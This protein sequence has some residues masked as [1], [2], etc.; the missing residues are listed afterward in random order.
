MINQDRGS[1]VL[2]F[3]RELIEQR[4]YWLQRLAEGW[5]SSGLRL[6]SPRPPVPSGRRG[7]VEVRIAGEAEARLAKLSGGQPFLLFAALMTGLGICLHRY[8]GGRRLV[9]GT[10]AL[11][12][13]GAE[14]PV[15]AVVILNVVEPGQ[16][17]RQLLLATRQTL[18]DAYARQDFPF[19]RLVE[20]KAAGAPAGGCPLFDVALVLEGL[21]GPLPEVGN[22]LTLR[23]RREPGVLACALSFDADVLTAETVLRFALHLETV[24]AGA[25]ADANAAV[26]RVPLL[27]EAEQAQ[28][29]REWN[30][31]DRGLPAFSSLKELFEDR[32][33]RTPEAV[34]ALYGEDSLTYGELNRRA[35]Q[36]AHFLHG[37]GVAPETLV[38]I[39]VERSFDM[40]TAVAGVLKA[41]GA[42]L[43]L[44][45][46]Y[47]QER[48]EL[49]VRD[50]GVPVLLTEEAQLG[51]LP[52]TA[53]RVVAMDRERA[54]IAACP[55][56]DP[57]VEV[58]PEN[59]A[60]VIYTS[61][62][63]GLP[64]GTQI[65]HAGVCNL[66]Q[67]IR[68][69]GVSAEDRVL[70]FAPL[71]FDAAVW[72]IVMA[73]DAGAA[74]CLGTREELHPGPDMVRLLQRRRVTVAS[75]PPSALAVLPE[76]QLKS[77]HMVVTA[78]EACPPEV[79][80]RWAKGRRLLNGY[81]PTEIT[82]GTGISRIAGD[83]DRPVIGYPFQN[84]R[85]FIL[86]SELRP[87]PVG[88]PGEVHVAGIGLAR[89][90]LGRPDLTAERFIPDPWSG[91][92]GGRLYK[93]GDVGRLMPD[94]TFDFL[95]RVDHQV[96][97][98]GLRVEL[99]EIESAL[100]LHPIAGEVV[101]DVREEVLVAWVV[102]RTGAGE[103][104]VPPARQLRE[105]LAGRLP[106]YMVPQ[107]FV[108]LAALPLSPSGKLDRR[109]L[110]APAVET[111]GREASPASLNPVE[112]VIAGLVRQV[113][114]SGS[115]GVRDDFFELGGNS[116]LAT[117]VVSRVAEAFQAEISLRGF[118]EE[119][120][121]AGLARQVEAAAGL[122]REVP[123]MVP[124]SR[125]GDL[126][127]SFSQQRLWF[128]DR[129]Q[130]GSALYNVPLAL[131]IEGDLDLDLLARS[132]GE[133]VRRHEVLRTVFA[134]KDGQPVQ[135]V[136]PFR[137]VDLPLVDLRGLPAEQRLEK[138][139]ETAKL[140]ARRPFDLAR[141]PLLRAAVLRLAPDEHAVLL[142]L[143][144]IASDGWSLGILVRE[145]TALFAGA[146]LEPLPIQYADFAAWQ[147][148]WLQGEVLEAQLDYWRRHLAGA[149]PVLDLPLDRP[150]PAV[151]SSHGASCGAA[152]TPELSDALA[153]VARAQ[154]VPLFMVLLSAYAVLLSRHGG[155]SDL[156][157]GTPIANRNRLETEKLIGFFVNTLALRVDLAAA[158][159]FAG[160]LRQV[161]QAAIGAYA[162]QDLPFEKLV[163][164]LRPAAD[165]SHT[166]L[167]QAMFVLQTP[168][169]EPR[170][171]GLALKP[172]E[173]DP[174]VA[175]FD[176]TLS[177][178]E[179]GGRLRAYLQYST[180]LFDAATVR[181]LL[182]HWETL[183]AGV[184]ADP[185]ARLSALPLLTAAE[186]QAVLVE[187]AGEAVP[188][189]EDACLHEIFAARAAE[190]P[191]TLAVVFEDRELTYAELD[192]RANR[193][194]HR[195]RRR[196]VGPEVRVALSLER[197]PEM[198]VALLAVMK[199]G[200]AYVPID[201]TYP[202]E[203]R[204]LML[205]DSGALLLLTQISLAGSL[206]A[207]A[208]GLA[209]L[210]GEEEEGGDDSAPLSGAAPENAAYVIYTSGSTGR[211]K[212]V[213]V[214]HRGLAN[215][216]TAQAL[217]FGL[218]PGAQVL[219]FSSMS[220]DASVFEIVMALAVGSTLVLARRETLIP[221][222][223]MIAL[224][225]ERRVSHV[226][227]PPS[228]LAALP[229]RDLPRLES[230][231]VAGEACP[232]ELVARW[233]GGR[234][235]WNAYGPTETT[236]WATVAP[237]S[238]PGKPPI[239]RP[240]A[241]ARVILLDRDFEPV[242][243]GVPG[244][245]CVGGAGLARGYHG[246]PALS[247]GRFV[248]D[249]WSGEPGARLYRTGDLARTLPDG[250]LE[251]LGRVDHQVK[252]RGF[253][254]EP[255]EVEAV[256]AE[257]PA[258]RDAVVLVREDRPGDRR[259]VAYAVVDPDAAVE[260]R[261]LREALRGRLPE[262]MV[263]ASFVL[264]PE[265]P[266]TGSG[267]VDR[268]ALPRPEA[269]ESRPLPAAA[270]LPR[271]VLERGI[272]EV[273]RQVLGREHVGVNDNF[274]DLGG[275][276]LLLV[277]VQAR[278]GELL[279]REVPM[280]DLFRHT[281]VAALAASLS[282]SE[283]DGREAALP[284]RPAARTETAIAIV[285][286]AGRFPGAPDVAAFWRNLR[287][288]V[289]AIRHFTG[290]E[291]AAAGVEAST[292]ANPSYVR[293]R[294]V[295]ADADRFDARFF[296]ISPREAE[297]MDPQHRLFLEGCWEA[298][299]DA[300][301]ASPHG[302]GAVGLFAGVSSN[303]YLFNLYSHPGLRE[304]FGTYQAT[305]GN[306]N[307]F[308][309]S[310]VSYKLDLKGPSVNVQT[311]CSTSLVAVHLACRALLD[312]ECDLALA[313]GVSVKAQQMA[314]YFYQEG[315]I[316][317]AN[318][319]CRSFD[320]NADG[321]VGGSGLGVVV[322]KRLDQALAD[323]D[324][325]RAVIKGSAINNDGA[326]RIG[327]TAPSVQGQAA[328]IARAQAAAGVSPDDV[329]YVEAHGTATP[330][331]DPIE[332]AA[333][334]EAFGGARQRN[335]CAVGAVKSNVGH[336]DAAAGVT[337]LIKTVLALEHGEIPPSLHFERPNPQIDF[338]GSP[339]FVNT[340]LTP[341]PKGDGP[342]RAGVSSFGIGGTNAHIVL[343]EAPPVP[344][345]GTE[346]A[347]RSH[348]LLLLSA[349]TP[350]ALDRAAEN[351]DRH[352]A[353]NPGLRLAD[354]ELTLQA[355][356]APFEHRRMVLAGGPE[357]VTVSGQ[358][359]EKDPAVAFL[360]PGQGAQYPGMGRELYDAE[361]VFARW[362]DRCAEVLEPEI[363]LDLRRLLFPPADEMAAAA[364]RLEQTALTQPALF[365]VEYALART[366]MEWGV[367]P[368]LM[369]GH[370]IG[371]YVA[372]TLAGV[373][374]LEEA[375]RLVALRGRLIQRLPGGAMLAVPLPE[376]EVAPLLAG[377]LAVAAVNA[378]GRTVVSG[379]T[380]EID[381]L[382]ER[383]TVQGVVHTRLH[384]SHAF[385][386]AA[387]DPVL[388][389]FTEA[390]RQAG[391]RPPSMPFLSNVTGREILPEE[392]SD[393]R[394]WA[395]HLRQA[396]R[397]G[398]N[399]R[400]L[401]EAGI[402]ILLEVGP[403]K[404]LGS[405]ARRA[406][407]AAVVLQSLSGPRQEES[408]VATMLG[409]LGR[410]WLAGV[411]ADWTAMFAVERRRRVPLP[412]YPFER[413][414]YWID[415]R[416]GGL[417]AAAV[418][419]RRAAPRKRA[420][421][422]DWF[423]VPVWKPT[424]PPVAPAPGAPRSFLVLAGEDTL[425]A[426]LIEGLTAEQVVTVVRAGGGFARLGEAEY[427]IDP[428]S[429]R[430][431]RALIAELRSRGLLPEAVV[432]LWSLGG[433]SFDQA[434]ERGFYSLLYLAQALA[435]ENVAEPL[436]IDVIADGLQ[437]VDGGDELAPEK[438]TLLGPCLVI[439]QEH[440]NLT[441]R[442]LD[443]VPPPAGSRQ[444]GELAARLVAELLAKP[445][446]TAVAYR[447]GRR[448]VQ[449]FEPVRVEAAAAPRADGVY[450]ITGGLGGVGLIL[451]E[452]LAR[453]GT[454][455]VLTG[456]SPF[457][458]REEWAGRLAAEDPASRAIRRILAIEELGA[459]V[460][461]R[462][463]DAADAGAM[464]E[465]VAEIR[466]R[467][468]AL[469]GVVH[470]AGVVGS[471]AVKPVELTGEADAETQFRAKVHGL[472]VLRD[473][474]RQAQGDAEL[475]F[476][477]LVSSLSTVLGGLGFAAYAAANR[478]MDAF[479][480]RE[481]AAGATPWISVDWDG[482]QL[483]GQE[484]AGGGLGAS[485]AQ[486]A[487]TPA[488]GAEAFGRAL[489]LTAEP[490]LVVST[491]DLEARLQAWKPAAAPEGETEAQ[492]ARPALE[493]AYLAPRDAEEESIAAVWRELL[494]LDRVG[495]EDDFFALGGDSL[496]A[497]QLLTRLRQ[498]TGA[499]IPLQAIFETP[500]VAGLAAT[501]A[502]FRGT[503]APP[504]VPVAPAAREGEIPLSF[505]QQRLWFLDQL[506]TAGS[507]Y[508]IFPAFRLAGRLDAGALARSLSE[509]ARR[510]EILRTVFPAVEG[511][512]IQVVQPAHPV[513]LP[514][515][516]LRGLPAER[517]EE[518]CQRLA[519]A[520]ARRPFDLARGPLLAATLLVLGEEEHLMFVAIHH[521]L[522]DG[523]SVGIFVREL[524]AL[525]AAFAQGQPSP[526]P[527]LP[528]QYAD[529]ALWQR[530]WLRGEVLDSQLD[531]WRRQLDG[532]QDLELPLDHPRPPRQSFRG[533]TEPLFLGEELSARVRALAQRT[534]AT[535][536]M[537][538]LAAFKVLLLR[539]TGQEDV[540]VGTNV[541]NRN[542]S[543]IEGL[544]GFFVN[545]LVL[546]TD[547]SGDPSFA[548]AVRRVRET[549]LGAFAHQDLPFE[550]L[551]EELR[552]ERDPSR[553]PL[554]QVIFVLQ[555]A[556]AE[557]LSLPGLT[558]SPF[559]IEKRGAAFDLLLN[560]KEKPE[561]LTGG[562]EYNTDL[563]EAES[564]RELLRYFTRLLESVTADPAAP[565]S[566][567]SLVE[568]GEQM[569]LISEFA[570]DLT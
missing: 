464:G 561:G 321:T 546:R 178:A 208:G 81:G 149:P 227:L 319:Q 570:G 79:A 261:E 412:T 351:L 110:P 62:S 71:S 194:A 6:D 380:E 432:H 206:P 14:P 331:G 125:D 44:D 537:T 112:E 376:A 309:P 187:G 371:E 155:Q 141:G 349:K 85:V 443:V 195:L 362:I 493:T 420:E 297:I 172:L 57:T 245:L 368:R 554:F 202:R 12:G 185:A 388:E 109:G 511:R 193:L 5:D 404:T 378:P 504:I 452:R 35:N 284:A 117:Q 271:T 104:G 217:A 153:T 359:G 182:G 379:P 405:F 126:P 15:N 425:A 515:V 303:S 363:G 283:G 17:V 128:L 225:E 148:G 131:R 95:G 528:V 28:V 416:P 562:L 462:R 218:R 247:A 56:G 248:P 281:T 477:L 295:L 42:Y 1:R 342:R 455:L 100:A 320:A 72:E 94:G 426:R 316:G 469:H 471:K 523:W 278:L 466:Q 460:L 506:S 453:P 168:A 238:G 120:T 147:R 549:S 140:E 173:S 352:L 4:D 30:D 555:I 255:G 350:E 8:T 130:P 325:I 2:I 99:G 286:M 525:Y 312:G 478:F 127:L 240:I 430:D 267:K 488:E 93:S 540:A 366:W 139:R 43:P 400:A 34:A 221:G 567:L 75:L 501:V 332:I 160:L 135:V 431:Y 123:P 338:A 58:H 372:A 564:I 143:H 323:G 132:L 46:S 13:D 166:P 433:A 171:P 165:L 291:L 356:R 49:M 395:R 243:P 450:L 307:N 199:A 53:A 310:R 465:L 251:F 418:D 445:A 268:A 543:E 394:Y 63:T 252:L 161:R 169:A 402:G 556:E 346:D 115:P 41:G 386:S 559:N 285:G 508:N 502:A 457:P 287:D 96:K 481:S 353:A 136:Q 228:V 565:I 365:A 516:D 535:L 521:I 382:A 82:V 335:Y 259:L 304:S 392:A 184:A 64:K 435:A 482:W 276:S 162:H 9:V 541:A 566:G 441:V 272:A 422:A 499:A 262:H 389:A 551:V 344:P 224:L 90:Y 33:R 447:R 222:P 214:V 421:I 183:L 54:A 55:E 480:E 391:P 415:M 290:E 145:L 39:C 32:A 300:G 20:E 503:Q 231:V 534:G 494:G 144:H 399:L 569:D 483:R 108:F 370:S 413:Q 213:V 545:N 568:D 485:Q 491:A 487:M 92:P 536:F 129:L 211:P 419:A 279:G 40:L 226:T 459:E 249:A 500:T 36:L 10:P 23:F 37:L 27:S 293:A 74:L 256:L 19:D 563:F 89:G 21:H 102:P 189:A 192:A 111:E 97:I 237:C 495:V 517:R 544:I 339:F 66:T 410:L 526:L 364:E 522:C 83:G 288:G 180:D 207:P 119:P 219:Q 52:S 292:I 355:G 263:P 229:E 47:P 60:Y 510:H 244:E 186:R 348:H 328:V 73:V 137:G 492:H 18:L 484:P 434:Q 361:P 489:A 322:L 250:N 159:T 557:T 429:P 531:Y 327:Y 354:V 383:L 69:L 340:R 552:P 122:G 403:G 407:G 381:E 264:L 181:R 560:M 302:R 84:V 113:L 270:A 65:A 334:T 203:R 438:A 456:R 223:G 282:P 210:D 142:T 26:S 423:Y 201:P 107:A 385:H 317:S 367:R 532:L 558:L 45:P 38:G 152:L 333:L 358:A 398:D 377:G 258:V 3:D 514:R 7:T 266:L 274:F 314:G 315:G 179:A 507:A 343:E 437:R 273:W 80:A 409:A 470:A 22:D 330:L 496:M 114:R 497:M 236:I 269:P 25:F 67:A 209:L 411:A 76:D 68:R 164:A 239:G 474:L 133:V 533:A 513:P 357:D 301:Y 324:T 16:T 31:T 529:F 48:I 397:F 505:S 463:C 427:A 242:P 439:P 204:E 197:S 347:Q 461:V 548:E 538:L 190:F 163:E 105:H 473:A 235:F 138:A 77:L 436:R 387:M 305:L 326:Q 175:K 360:F 91:V 547:L 103:P 396:V 518:E 375:L 424:A 88:V 341:W 275:H 254:I 176:L 246:S 393:P 467:F 29:V 524:P 449:G 440:R 373:F 401:E 257:H 550:R 86:D 408:A 444:E 200:G 490:R 134:V 479:A 308:L 280:I 520:V 337:G 191:D 116:L 390:V 298:L 174:G 454:R 188:F 486:L 70:Q 451:A 311:A 374:T 220:F 294:G 530:D 442:S 299:E 98:R 196:G 216:V 458:A 265:F 167:F 101:V 446:G 24:L 51:R 553:Q 59:L 428:R 177:M 232:A 384:T 539:Y 124:V 476:C 121:V 345:E 253:R 106:Q 157:I 212:G 472:Y 306:D 414:R 146:D 296:G 509:M 498:A 329:T 417:A 512:P 154:G 151:Q 260:A 170:L 289:E 50:S 468:G 156:V 150:R 519:M 369:A 61:G 11:A 318:G 118:F 406:D 241:N 448:L 205:A 234:R 158:P 475:D 277:Q 313:G 542:R 215:L 527:E 78:G 230:I 336:L 198:I 87:V 233:A